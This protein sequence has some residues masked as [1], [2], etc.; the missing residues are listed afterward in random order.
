MPN[1]C[2][3]TLTISHPDPA[4]MEKARQAWNDGKFLSTF[5]PEPNHEGYMNCEI[6]E[7]MPEWWTWRLANWGT[8]WEVS[9]EP[10]EIVDGEIKVVFDSAW[11]PPIN[12]YESMT[13]QGFEVTAYYFEP[14]C[15]FCGRY[16]NG[17]DDCYTVSD[18]DFPQDVDDEM[19]ITESMQEYWDEQA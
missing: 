6:K 15:D 2:M 19:G 5:V 16:A 10:C 11:S 18:R 8:K 1:W 13:E 9:G 7:G 14:G 4:M 3:N 12:A 17:F